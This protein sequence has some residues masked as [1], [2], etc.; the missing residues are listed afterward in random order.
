MMKETRIIASIAVTVIL[1]IVMGIS[2]ALAHP[3]DG[4]QAKELH[5]Y[6]GTE[7]YGLGPEYNINELYFVRPLPDPAT[8]TETEKYV[9]AGLTQDGPGHLRQAY[10]LDVCDAALGYCLNTKSMPNEVSTEMLITLDAEPDCIS[11]E[12][13]ERMTSPISGQ[14]PRLDA[15]DFSP[16]DFYI[17]PL[18]E[19]EK[20]H[21]ASL[22]KEFE[23]LWYEGVIKN[24]VS[25]DVKAVDL[26]GNT[27]LYVCVYGENS[28]ILT[29]LHFV[30]TDAG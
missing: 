9:L 13:L 23:E 10:Y 30:M 17:R 4:Y 5:P 1:I 27:V 15:K 26:I 21:F 19:D 29:G 24:P 18:T 14:Y 11:P 3:A 7:K 22:S 25:G 12:R 8:L 6:Y 16:G 2:N 28:V 20:R